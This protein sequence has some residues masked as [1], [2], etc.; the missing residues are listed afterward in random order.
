[1]LRHLKEQLASLRWKT[2][3]MP[4]NPHSGVQLQLLETV[5]VTPFGDAADYARYLERLRALPRVV[6]DWIAVLEQGRK[7]RLVLFR[8]LVEES[9][10]QCTAIAKAKGMNS[11]FSKPLEHFPESMPES[12]RKEWRQTILAAIDTNVRPEYAKLA[13]V[14]RS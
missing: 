13:G 5:S 4:I 9:I 12:Q 14:G 7:D 1:M 6:E 2:Y 11:P 10:A 3:E 8:P